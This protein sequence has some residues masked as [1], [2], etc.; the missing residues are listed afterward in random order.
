[1]AAQLAAS[2]EVLSRME[3]VRH[4]AFHEAETDN[5]LVGQQFPLLLWH[6]KVPYY[7]H[8][9]PPLVHIL[10]RKKSVEKS[11]GLYNIS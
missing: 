2:Q 9:S 1:V 3:L 6:S 7:V 10:K 8:K 4:D 5:R 11:V